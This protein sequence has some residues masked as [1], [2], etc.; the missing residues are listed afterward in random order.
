MICSIVPWRPAWLAD[1]IALSNSQSLCY[2]D[3]FHQVST[4]SHLIRD[5]I[6]TEDFQDGHHGC[7]LRC[8]NKMILAIQEQMWFED[9]Q[10]GHRAVAAI[11]DMAKDTFSNSESLCCSDTSHQV[12][13]QSN[14][15]FGR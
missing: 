14:L 12:S 4:H 3:A 7:N 11:L 5:E 6:L 13:A 10:D 8:H 1:Q 9:F 15:K 2:L